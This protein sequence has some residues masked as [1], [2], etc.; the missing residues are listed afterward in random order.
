M[1]GSFQAEVLLLVH[2]IALLIREVW[3]THQ[4]TVLL[5]RQRDLSITLFNK[6]CEHSGKYII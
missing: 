5:P 1:Q 6:Q 2:V 4:L 3:G